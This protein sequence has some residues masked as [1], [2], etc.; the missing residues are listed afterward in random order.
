M[1]TQTRFRG[2]VPAYSNSIPA[3]QKIEEELKFT[4]NRRIN[5]EADDLIAVVQYVKHLEDQ[6]T[7]FTEI[8]LINPEPKQESPRLR[9]PKL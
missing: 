1:V 4:F 6:L 7:S 9:I 2:R 3:V 5:V 8:L